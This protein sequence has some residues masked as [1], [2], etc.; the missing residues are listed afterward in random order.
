MRHSKIDSLYLNNNYNSRDQVRNSRLIIERAS[1]DP[2]Q[3]KV[4]FS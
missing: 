3:F 4:R 2:A 1:Q